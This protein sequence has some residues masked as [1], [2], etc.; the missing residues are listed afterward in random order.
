[1]DW[2]MRTRE[3][4]AFLSGHEVVLKRVALYLFKSHVDNGKP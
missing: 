4:G 3:G 1:M 2:E